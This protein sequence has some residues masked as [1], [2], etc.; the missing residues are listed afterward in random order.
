MIG[1]GDRAYLIIDGDNWFC[2]PAF[3]GHTPYLGGQM[4]KENLFPSE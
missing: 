4:L 3:E 2:N 1:R